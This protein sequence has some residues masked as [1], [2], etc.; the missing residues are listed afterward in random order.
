LMVIV[1]E[2]NAGAMEQLLL[3][4]L[5]LITIVVVVV[6]SIHIFLFAHAGYLAY[7][8]RVARRGWSTSRGSIRLTKRKRTEVEEEAQAR[9]GPETNV[10]LDGDDDAQVRRLPRGFSLSSAVSSA[11]TASSG[12]YCTQLRS[13][14]GS[15]HLHKDLQSFAVSVEILRRISDFVQSRLP[16]TILCSFFFCFCGDVAK[17]FRSCGVKKAYDLFL[18][19]RLLLLYV[20]VHKLG[21]LCCIPGRQEDDKFCICRR[22]CVGSLCL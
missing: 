12:D 15:R 7:I 13:C 21:S 10:A 16:I 1:M 9:A 2:E 8:F 3:L 17:N 18:L 22:Y 20:K 5:F 19:R 4:L 6:A 11:Q 14:C